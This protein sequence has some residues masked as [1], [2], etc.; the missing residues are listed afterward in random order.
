MTHP[1]TVVR[2]SAGTGKTYRLTN[3]FLSLIA[4]G[5]DPAAIFGS[6]FTRKAAGEIL[7]RILFRLAE[8]CADPQRLIQLRA[9]I[10]HELPE[11]VA[12]LRAVAER[13][14]RLGVMTIDA[15]CIRA[16]R[17]LALEL[18]ASPAWSI[19]DPATLEQLKLQAVEEVAAELGPELLASALRGLNRGH[20]PRSVHRELLHSIDVA[21]DVLTRTQGRVEPWLVVGPITELCG[22]LQSAI[23]AAENAPLPL[24]KKGAPPLPWVKALA[25]VVAAAR[26]GDWREVVA[27]KFSRACIE[28]ASFSTHPFPPELHDA[29][30]PLIHHA[31]HLVLAV[32]RERN[33]AFADLLGRLHA[34]YADAKHRAGALE[35]SDIPALLSSLGQRLETLYFRLDARYRHILLDEFQDTSLEQFRM[36]E[37]MLDEL[38]SSGDFR[39]SLCVGDVKQSLYAWRGAE[40]GLLPRLKVR[41]PQLAET[42]LAVS[43]RSSPVI[44]DVLNRTFEDLGANRAFGAAPWFLEAAHHWSD[45]Y[46]RHEAAKT[47]P[48][49][50]RLLAGADGEYS[51]AQDLCEQAAVERAAELHARAPAASIAILLRRGKHMPRIVRALRAMGVDASQEGGGPLTDSPPV[52]ALLS[53][54]HLADYPGDTA[55]YFH[56]ATSPLGGFLNLFPH[57]DPAACPETS[58][59]LRRIIADQGLLG[60]LRTAVACIA[61]S[62]DAQGLESCRKLLDLAARFQSRGGESPSDFIRLVNAT[63]VERPGPQRVRVMTIH[64]SKGLEFDAVILPELASKPPPSHAPLLAEEHDGIFPRVTLASAWPVVPERLSHPALC[65]ACAQADRRALGE[66]LCLLYVAMSR[67]IHSLD[68]IIPCNTNFNASDAAFPTVPSHARIL[69]GALTD[70]DRASPDTVLFDTG[71]DAWI[72][73]FRTV[74]PPPAPKPIRLSLAPPPSRPPTAR[75]KRLSPAAASLTPSDLLRAPSPD[76]LHRG[77][78]VHEWLALTTWLDDGVPD[79]SVFLHTPCAQANP[80][81]AAQALPPFLNTLA[82]P[83]LSSLLSRNRY[84]ASAEASVERPFAVRLEDDGE[85]ALVTGCFDRLVIVRDG[86]GRAIEAEIIDFKTDAV[87][88]EALDSRVQFHQPQMC[89]YRRAAAA[90]L[91][92]PLD[93]IRATLAF[94]DAGREVSV[95]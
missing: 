74:A 66:S 30:C 48:G 81:L 80:S 22:D 78:L 13:L 92:L 2:A 71:S 41:W 20:L 63:P 3:H 90:M 56:V 46:D 86:Q 16:A 23:A 17:S 44:L 93:R 61:A 19:A 88:P 27:D 62:T 4:Q 68:L 72:D 12:A 54:L 79:S 8:A 50:V 85:P 7:R 67:A 1:H 89:L 65:D 64:A 25:R 31:S 94:L 18:P 45:L 28:G 60:L 36:L 73:S 32:L 53:M 57:P 84:A 87:A 42:P 37:P 24:T 82:S 15:F 21:R 35:F 58:S 76:A 55:A 83:F 70:L 26:A 10:G 49:R 77:S 34:A 5:E 11:P 6:T 33:L 91:A 52:L 47:L 38:L 75:L 29:L 40:P 95:G 14:D 43:Y 69:L 9:A 51:E 39:T 59:R